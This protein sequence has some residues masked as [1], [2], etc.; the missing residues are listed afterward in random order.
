MTWDPAQY[1]RFAAEREEPFWDLA[2]LLQPVAAPRLVDLGCGDGRL[3]A[4]LHERIGAARTTGIDSSPE[5][6]AAAEACSTETLAFRRGD[7]AT[8]SGTADIVVANASLHWVPDHERVLSGW[9]AGLDP[10]GQLAVQVPANSDHPSHVVAREVAEDRLGTA[11]PVDPVAVNV[12]ALERYAELLDELGFGRQIVRLQ[13]YGHRLAS[14]ADV[15]EWMKGTSLRRFRAVM[16]DD[17]WAGYV[18]EYRRRLLE[19]LGARAPY[20]FAFK[21]I[22]M[23]GRLA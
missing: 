20:F 11:A 10:G 14:T 19:R 15:V 13:V 8:W 5:M 17:Q 21:R 12:L 23:W 2:G 1:N 16:D 6:L 3:T 4:A 22:L 9:R 7:L 18:D